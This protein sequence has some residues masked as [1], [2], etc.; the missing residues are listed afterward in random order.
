MEGMAAAEVDALV[1]AA[2]CSFVTSFKGGREFPG[3]SCGLEAVIFALKASG[4][5]SESSSSARDIVLLVDCL[6]KMVVDVSL[7]FSRFRV[8]DT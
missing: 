7:L 3:E 4:D 2:V 1:F 8:D 5:G 6:V